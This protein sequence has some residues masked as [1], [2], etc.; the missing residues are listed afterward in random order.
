MKKGIDIWVISDTHFGHEKLKEY[1]SRPDGF[2]EKILKS[3]SD[4]ISAEREHIIIH[5][6]DVCIGQ[7]EYWHE[8]LSYVH[9]KKWLVRGNHDKKSLS[10]YLS[11]GWDFVAD[12]ITLNIYGKRVC[13]SHRPISDFSTGIRFD[14]NV[15]GHCHADNHRNEGG[16]HYQ[17][18][19]AVEHTYAPVLLRSILEKK[20]KPQ[21]EQ[22][23]DKIFPS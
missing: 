4:T 5:L 17:R 6:G 14:I 7:D 11:H 15:H 2:E 18:L 8:R 22:S 19:V 3:L 10:W 21:N 12:E 9:C 1:A 23:A 16:L 20:H 13:F